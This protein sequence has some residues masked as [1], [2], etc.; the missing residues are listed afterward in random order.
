[1]KYFFFI[2]LFLFIKS[3]NATSVLKQKQILSLANQFIYNKN[4]NLVLKVNN[5]I[6]VPTCFGQV[7]IIDKYKNLKTLQINCLGSKPWK[8]NLR[9]NIKNKILKNTKSL[10][11]KNKKISALIYS[12]DLKKGHIITEKDLKLKYFSSI[13]SNNIFKDSDNLIGR[14]TKINL[15]KGQIIRDRHLAKNWIIKE[16]QKV[17][18]E[19][20]TG[21]L[22]ILVDGIALKSGMKG[23]YLQVKNENSGK[24]IK[25]WVKNNKKITIFSL[26][27]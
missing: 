21:N 6:K 17:K 23:D 8:Y 27:F 25:G 10:P 26:N 24:I 2:A 5:K 9:T 22:V 1:M 16:G 15:K 4:Q 19:H 12:K 20:K 13:G 3:L 14:S 11:N 7:Q 18:I